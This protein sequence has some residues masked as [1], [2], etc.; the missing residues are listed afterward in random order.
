[1]ILEEYTEVL[2]RPKFYLEPQAVA[3][4]LQDLIR[5]ATIVY[6]TRRVDVDVARPEAFPP[7]RP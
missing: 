2:H 5:A 6:P 3:L 4:F 7:E 1:M